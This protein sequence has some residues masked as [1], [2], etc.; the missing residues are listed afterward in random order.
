M[1]TVV[2]D[3][4]PDT[5]KSRNSFTSPAQAESYIETV[6]AHWRTEAD[7]STVMM[8]VSKNNLGGYTFTR[9]GSD[10]DDF[11]I[12]GRVYLEM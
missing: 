9:E 2:T 12:W 7:T 10:E 5:P 6:A 3:T 11:E 1:V 8:L 4:G